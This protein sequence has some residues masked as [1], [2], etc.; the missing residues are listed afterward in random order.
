MTNKQDDYVPALAYDGLTRF[1]DPLI[2]MALR[3]NTFK[4]AL[5]EQAQIQNGQRVLDLA[6]G[7][8]TLTLMIKNACP[9]AEVTGVD[10]DPKIL[11]I[12][13]GKIG[14]AQV[15]IVLDEAMSFELPYED[16]SFDRVLSS[17]FFH[18]L[19]SENKTRTAVEL[20]RI[21]KPGGSLHVAD[22]GKPQNLAMAGAILSVRFLDG[23]DITAD[24]VKGRLPSFFD[25]AG[26]ENAGLHREFATVMGT[27][28]LYSAQKPGRIPE[29]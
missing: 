22:W 24:N 16:Q 2:A 10:G 14:K 27:I 5:I 11:S 4:S 1:Y 7:T 19:T 9:D 13:R 8:A 29:N 3:E 26:F 25:E 23:F 21:L 12:A 15:D 6:C 17:L 28:A 20:Y 18:H